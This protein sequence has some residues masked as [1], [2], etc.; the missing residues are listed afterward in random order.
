MSTK[1]LLYRGSRDGT[2]ATVFHNKCNSIKKT[3]TIIKTTNNYVFG[4]Y[5][6]AAWSNTAGYVSDSSAYLFVL[7]RGSTVSS[8]IHFGVSSAYNAIYNHPSNGPTF[9]YNYDIRIPDRFDINIGS[10]INKTYY[11]SSYGYINSYI[12]SSWYASDVEVFQT[13]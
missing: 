11:N 10:S 12:D 1:K 9:G 13:V 5:T 3:L 4:G 6:G 7:R 2:S 8:L